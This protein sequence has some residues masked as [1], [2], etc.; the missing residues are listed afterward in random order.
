MVFDS[1]VPRQVRPWSLATLLLGC[2]CVLPAHA[3]SLT[4]QTNL[5]LLKRELLDYHARAYDHDLET[6][7]ADAAAW[8][9]KRA[10]EVHNPAIVLDIDETSLSNW[11]E[12]AANDFAFV[13]SG[14]CAFPPTLPCGN[15]AWDQS[16]RAIAIAPTLEVYREARKLGVAVFFVTG[17]IEDPQERSA[18]EL[19][20]WKVGYEGWAGLLMRKDSTG[21]VE[22]FKTGARITIEGK[23]TII[24]NIGD[25]D[26][27]LRGGH[28][29]KAY[30]VPNPFYLI[31]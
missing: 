8:I 14:P 30:K 22:A 9:A 20:L 2:L 29:E 23:Y 18:T 17:R 10:K 24:A 6:A 28:A 4:P 31:P 7:L 21:T 3:Q 15:L 5:G 16:A 25:Q 13:P 27:D 12:I 11:P 19:N 26:S 1:A